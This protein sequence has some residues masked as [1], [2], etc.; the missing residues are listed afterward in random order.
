[1]QTKPTKEQLAARLED[2]YHGLDDERTE[3]QA[4]LVVTHK[5]DPEAHRAEQLRLSL[6]IHAIQAV[7]L[8]LSHRVEKLIELPDAGPS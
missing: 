7:Q 8:Y 6:A 1:M 2:L 5:K 4:R 3:L